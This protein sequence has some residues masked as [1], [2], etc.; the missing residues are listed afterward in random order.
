MDWSSGYPIMLFSLN[1]FQ[2]RSALLNIKFNSAVLFLRKKLD[3]LFI[4]IDL[5][6]QNFKHQ[7]KNGKI[8]FMIYSNP[9]GFSKLYLE[10][11]HYGKVS[12]KKLSPL[13]SFSLNM[14]KVITCSTDS[15]VPST[16]FILLC[17][18]RHTGFAQIDGFIWRITINI[19]KDW[20]VAWLNLT[21]VA[22]GGGVITLVR[23]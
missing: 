20:S 17:E 9:H 18:P 11:T 8:Y 22:R 7:H 2:C 14:S 16:T 1:I 10:C 21:W 13:P 3:L 12:R 5:C 19:W 15:V 23:W 4:F 6:F